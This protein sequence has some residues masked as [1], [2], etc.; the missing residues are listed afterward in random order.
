MYTTTHERF[1]VCG[2]NSEFFAGTIWHLY[3]ASIPSCRKH[4]KQNGT[5]YIV[6]LCTPTHKH[7][8]SA[9]WAGRVGVGGD[10]DL[11]AWPCPYSPPGWG[12]WRTQGKGL[13]NSSSH[14]RH[15]SRWDREPET[16]QD[17]RPP[18]VPQGTIICPVFNSRN[19]LTKWILCQFRSQ[20]IHF[21]C[22]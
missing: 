16:C 7:C 14:S 20:I 4:W 9:G 2:K 6:L 21:H 5:I 11:S 3:R 13:E 8:Q 22:V 17:S 10:L 19:C 1:F 12:E 18:L 15:G